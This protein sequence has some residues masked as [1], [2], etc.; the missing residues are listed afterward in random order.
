MRLAFAAPRIFRSP[1]WT[2]LAAVLGVAAP[3]TGWMSSVQLAPPPPSAVSQQLVIR[4][5]ER[6]LAQLGAV[7][8]PFDRMAV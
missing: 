3:A 4:S 2:R 5:L 6:S 7:R 1:G 8:G